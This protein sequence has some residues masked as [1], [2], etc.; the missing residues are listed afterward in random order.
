M[1]E[2]KGYVLFHCHHLATL[3]QFVWLRTVYSFNEKV[4]LLVNHKYFSSST[5]AQN[6]IKEKVFD[7]IICI[8]EPKNFNEKKEE[9][10]VRDYYDQFFRDNDL[11]FFD[12]KE[13]YT[14]CDLNNLF[15]IYC[16]LNSRM[17]SYIEMYEGQFTDYSRY[18]ASTKMF[19]YPSWWE[20]LERKYNSLSG[21]GG[22]Y[23][24]KRLLWPG[25]VLEY[26]EKDIHVDFLGLFYSLQN[27]YKKR[28]RNCFPYFKNLLLEKSFVF[29]LNSPRWT[30]S[31]LNLEMQDYYKPYI[32]ILDYFFSTSKN[33]VIKKHPHAD[34]SDKIDQIFSDQN[35]V[36]P[37]TL[38]IEFLGLFDNLK[39]K[40][41]VSVES[42]GNTKI[43]RFVEKEVKL[44]TK[45]L[46]AYPHFHKLVFVQMVMNSVGNIEEVRL[47]KEISCFFEVIS[48]Y[49][50]SLPIEKVAFEMYES[51]H[52]IYVFSKQDPV[53]MDI[54]MTYE[55]LPN[56][57]ICFFLDEAC[58]RY[59][60]CKQKRN[61]NYINK[62]VVTISIASER[63]EERTVVNRNIESVFILCK[64]KKLFEEL[65][66][67]NLEYKLSYSGIT[68]R[69]IG[70]YDGN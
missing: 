31:I 45:M 40:K 25:S 33:L 4:V 68:V 39:I 9:T 41:L 5:F 28:I 55:N 64:D 56:N 18:S 14:A 42:S 65:R 54:L 57:I 10:F 21:D 7:R 1:I 6:L 23:T 22:K 62:Q 34:A 37:N 66:Y 29:L 15:P 59:F 8:Q 35:C 58:L 44:G 47:D 32:L 43:G 36:I 24:R 26:S 12:I 69:I 63:S 52:S 13:I 49:S 2:K 46:E 20:L 48:K 17:L 3:Y 67:I 19:G 16:I 53:L 38:P 61:L 70:E 11:S 30:A 60:L 51:S 27:E 50:L